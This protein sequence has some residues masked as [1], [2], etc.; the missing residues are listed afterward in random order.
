MA[1]VLFALSFQKLTETPQDFTTYDLKQRQGETELLQPMTRLFRQAFRSVFDLAMVGCPKGQ[2]AV[3]PEAQ[4]ELRQCCLLRSATALELGGDRPTWLLIVLADVTPTDPAL[5]IPAWWQQ[6]FRESAR[7]IALARTIG[8]GGMLDQL[9]SAPGFSVGHTSFHPDLPW[10]GRESTISAVYGFYVAAW[11]SALR[12]ERRQLAT[13]V[14]PV[15]SLDVPAGIE[16][17]NQRLRIL[18]QQRFFLTTDRS[19]DLELRGLCEALATKYRIAARNARA[20]ELH[21]AFEHHLDNSAKLHSAR[22]LGSVSNLILILTILSVPISFFSAIFAIN[23]KS[24][25]LEKPWDLMGDYRI[26]VA[27]LIG[28]AVVGIPFLL[29]KLFDRARLGKSADFAA[30][31]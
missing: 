4:V 23:L 16:I 18:N 5:D 12:I 28:T 6:H 20:L 17:A 25:A 21:A 3:M 26:Y 1:A 13:R 2:P 24:E 19:N 8:L 14:E 9:Q 31:S 30:D 22:E 10:T 27:F 15:A 11:L 7:K 29:L